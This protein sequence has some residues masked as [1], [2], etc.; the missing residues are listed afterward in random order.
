MKNDSRLVKKLSFL[1]QLFTE[2]SKKT[3]IPYTAKEWLRSGK[4]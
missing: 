2:T 1:I 3:A 4:E